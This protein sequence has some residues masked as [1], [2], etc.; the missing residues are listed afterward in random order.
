MAHLVIQ[1][2]KDVDLSLYLSFLCLAYTIHINL[3]PGNFDALLL[4]ITFVYCF[5]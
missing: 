4:V 1:R 3:A 2:L 5:E